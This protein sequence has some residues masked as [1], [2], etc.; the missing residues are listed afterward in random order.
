MYLQIE[1]AILR[2]EAGKTTRKFTGKEVFSMI[3]DIP[4]SMASS[5][6]FQGEYGSGKLTVYGKRLRVTQ[7]DDPQEFMEDL[8]A[9]LGESIN[10]YGMFTERGDKFNMQMDGGEFG[11][12]SG[13]E[14]DITFK[15]V[16]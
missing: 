7:T 5:G 12:E 13:S 4:Y 1:N 8:K 9:E 2:N 6:N 14:I 16:Y 15:E 11:H 10:D 3:V